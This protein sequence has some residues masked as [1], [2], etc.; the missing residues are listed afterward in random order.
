MDTIGIGM[1]GCGM[2]G[3]VHALGY[4]DLALMYPGQ[5]PAVHL[6]AVCT[7]RPETACAAAAE[8]GFGAWC[9]DLAELLARDDVDVVDCVAPNYL[10]H[11][12]VL[13]AIAAGKHVYCEKPLALDGAQ[14]REIAHA[15]GRG[16][17]WVGMVFNYRFVP[18]VMRARQLAEAGALGEVYS[19]RAA[20]LHSGYQDPL[21]PMSWR[22]RR[23]QA[24]GGALV[25]L[26]SHAID[27]IRHLLGE[28]AAVRAT[29]CTYIKERPA[30]KGA[31]EMEP[32]TVDDA[33][34]LQARLVSG[35]VGTIEASRFATGMV[36]DLRFEIH[37]ERGALR[38]GLMDPNWLYW[39]DAT[40]PGGAFGGERGWTRLETVQHYPGAAVPP[41]RAPVGW[42]RTLA[43]NQA[44]FLRAVARGERPQPDV[45][46]GL[47]VQLVLDAAYESART[48]E[49]VPVGPDR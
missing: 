13:A 23:E 38:F 28:F 35:A 34:W 1:V 36:D 5:L 48:G 39:Y 47:R 37:G 2:I 24:G 33:A 4:R 16:G 20:Y 8:A 9:T 49:W 40:R 14:A 22:L 26:G 12:V 41:A 32:V 19:F 21:R 3:R 7:S 11:R 27:L 10:H 25:D 18:A 45:T 44:A 43:E 42:A 15:A 6:T 29:A 30:R 46:D 31:A 17:V